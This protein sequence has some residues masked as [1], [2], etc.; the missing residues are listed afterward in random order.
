MAKA[1]QKDITHVYVDEVTYE[2]LKYWADKH[3]MSIREYIREAI[4]LA[5]RFE[6]RDYDLPTAEQARLNQLC[7]MAASLDSNI[8]TLSDI[9]QTGFAS[10]LEMTRGENYLIESDDW[11]SRSGKTR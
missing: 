8:K 9:V 6:N 10:L 3:D 5:I 1:G 2:R 4:E 7:D 11:G